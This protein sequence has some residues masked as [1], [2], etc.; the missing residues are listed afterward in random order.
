MRHQK[1]KAESK[2]INIEELK[3]WVKTQGQDAILM[4]TKDGKP[5]LLIASED[6]KQ[7]VENAITLIDYVM[8]IKRDMHLRLCRSIE[9][10]LSKSNVNST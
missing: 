10:I 3:V 9:Q 5:P 2:E 6:K 8:D 4:P 1:R 7:A